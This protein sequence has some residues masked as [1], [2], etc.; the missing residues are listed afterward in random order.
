L[1]QATKNHF[2]ENAAKN[3]RRSQISGTL[4]Y[5]PKL[6]W[7]KFTKVTSRPPYPVQDILPVEIEKIDADRKHQRKQKAILGLAAG[8]SSVLLPFPPFPYAQR[9]SKDYYACRN[10]RQSWKQIA[11]NEEGSREVRR[12]GLDC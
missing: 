3:R 9:D 2:L 7:R 8:S 1:Q 6:W 4:K 11:L 10:D 5:D 12:K